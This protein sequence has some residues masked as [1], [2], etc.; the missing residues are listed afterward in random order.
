MHTRQENG[1][2]QGLSDHLG[3]TFTWQPPLLGSSNAESLVEGPE[4]ITLEELDAAFE[5]LDMQYEKDPRTLPV[6]PKLT[7]QNIE[8]T[9]V[10][11]LQELQRIN[12]GV[13]ITSNNNSI[14]VY[15]Y[16]GT[17]SSGGNW[18]ITSLLAEKGI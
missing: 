8:A 7:G 2:N 1:I 18:D 9:D 5:E 14:S 4:S 13:R 12:S 11:D 3:R 16:S 17:N 15:D 10:Y 6:D